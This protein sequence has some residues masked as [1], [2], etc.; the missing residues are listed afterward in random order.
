MKLNLLY[1]KCLLDLAIEEFVGCYGNL[2]E[3]CQDKYVLGLNAS[4]KTLHTILEK[5]IEDC[6][7]RIVDSCGKNGIFLVIGSCYPKDNLLLDF[8]DD[9]Y[10]PRKLSNL[11][12]NRPALKWLLREKDI[13]IDIDLFNEMFIDI[14]N[15]MFNKHEPKRSSMPTCKTVF[16]SHSRLDCYMLFKTIKW[17]YGNSN[18]CNIWKEKL[19]ERKQN[20][21]AVNDLVSKYIHNKSRMN[22]SIEFKR[23][24][25]EVKD[26]LDKK[27]GI[28]V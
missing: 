16:V 2:F 15:K 12:D 20:L 9:N 13:E 27:I 22:R 21:V 6:L 28:E 11:I 24:A 26:Y 1:Y 19:I 5:C 17:A 18:C 25:L 7:N 3:K 10:F 23:Y 14:F 8:K 4:K